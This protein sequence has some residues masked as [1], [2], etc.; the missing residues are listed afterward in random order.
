M[1]MRRIHCHFIIIISIIN[2]AP[3]SQGKCFE[4]LKM[5]AEN[6]FGREQKAGEA[7]DKSSGIFLWE[8]FAVTPEALDNVCEQVVQSCTR[9]CSGWD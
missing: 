4:Y 8:T 2:S 3:E 6:S 9:H 5:V 7:A 1:L